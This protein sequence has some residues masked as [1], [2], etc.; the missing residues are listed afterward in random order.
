MGQDPGSNDEIQ[1]FCR[2]NYG[3]TFPV[4]AKVEVNGDNE[5]P[6]FGFLKDEKKSLMMKRVKWNFEKWLVGRDG[7]VVERYSSNAK[8]ESLE[9]AVERELAKPAPAGGA[10][11]PEMAKAEL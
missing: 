3:V 10:G 2:M 4:L 6:V 7:K 1:S 8:P 11:Q 9:A 5:E